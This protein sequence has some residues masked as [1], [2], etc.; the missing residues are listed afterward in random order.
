MAPTVAWIFSLSL[1][2][3]PAGALAANTTPPTP[4][5]GTDQIR[6]EPESRRITTDVYDYLPTAVNPFVFQRIE[7]NGIAAVEN[8]GLDLYFKPKGFFNIHLDE[9]DLPGRIRQTAIET[10]RVLLDMDFLLRFLFFRIDV[11]VSTS[12]AFSRERASMPLTFKVPVNS[13][14]IL[15]EGSGALYSWDE[16]S[17]RISHMD[18]DCRKSGCQFVFSGEISGTQPGDVKKSMIRDLFAVRMAVPESLVAQGFFP[19]LVR[20][21]R[22]LATTRGWPVFRG[23]KAPRTG[24]YFELSG[25]G[26]GEYTV[27][28]DIGILARSTP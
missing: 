23:D 8:A 9:S 2:V 14:A 25:L 18:K 3:L 17:A 5:P 15:R 21:H 24:I 12:A 4:V 1:T 16:K 26:K 20:D 28:Y 11:D 7:F 6:F 19:Q 27:A 13:R 10:G 22:E